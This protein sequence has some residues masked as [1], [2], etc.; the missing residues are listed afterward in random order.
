[1]SAL[2]FDDDFAVFVFDYLDSREPS[3][4]MMFSGLHPGV[5]FFYNFRF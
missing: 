1:M 3:R 2:G 5:N 4:P